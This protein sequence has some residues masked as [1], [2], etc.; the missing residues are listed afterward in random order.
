MSTTPPPGAYDSATEQ[1]SCGVGL[2]V[3]LKNRKSHE[4]CAIRCQ[5]LCNLEHRGA[6]VLRGEYGRRR[7]DS[8]SDAQSLS[9][10]DVPPSACICLRRSL[11][12]RQGFFCRPAERHSHA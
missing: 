3:Y 11:R 6:C 10:Q 4:S 2:H 12:R 5:I 8:H 1:D 9:R 7:G